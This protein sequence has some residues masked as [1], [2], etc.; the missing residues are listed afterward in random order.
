MRDGAWA[1]AG[2]LPPT[3][4]QFGGQTA[5]WLALP[6]EQ[7]GVPNPGTRV[8][9]IGL[10]GGPRRLAA[11]M[12]RPGGAAPQGAAVRTVREALEIARAIGYPVLVRPSY[13]LG[14]RAMEIVRTEEALERYV[15]RVV[16]QF[17]EHPILIDR[18]LLGRE[19]EV[20]ALCDGQDV[21]I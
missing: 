10:R 18:Y 8:G 19:V 2:G 13:V 14:G 1:G 4:V 5:I 7:A 17:G 3:V 9:M 6:L 11:P 20:D 12:G 15:G 16:E 21:L